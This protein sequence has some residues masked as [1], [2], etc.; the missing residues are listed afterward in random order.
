MGSIKGSGEFEKLLTSAGDIELRSVQT[1]S[2]HLQNLLQE[3]EIIT[4]L[5]NEDSEAAWWADAFANQVRDAFNDLYES[6]PCLTI[7]NFPERF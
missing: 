1:S 3:A 7:T 4:G 5:F 2:I 6:S